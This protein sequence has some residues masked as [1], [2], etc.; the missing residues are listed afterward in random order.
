MK[1]VRGSVLDIGCGA[2]RHSLYLQGE[3]FDVT[4]IDK[5]TGAIS[6]CKM[7]GLKN[8]RLLSIDNIGKLPKKYFNTVIM[9]GNNFGLF[10]SPVKTR[11]LLTK[12][13]QITAPHA[14]IIAECRDPYM[15]DD[16][17]HLGYHKFNRKRGRLPGQLRLRIR[18]KN[19]VGEWFDYLFVSPKEMIRILAG[20]GW[21]LAEVL[22]KPKESEY[23]AV[24]KKA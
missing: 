3:G 13:S 5:S 11:R 14:Q 22:R 21:K 20:T 7:R 16:P 19:I 17:V 9:M 1:T 15:T 10:G 18:Y 6:V 8:I 4:G 24:I 23:I 2:G 12:M